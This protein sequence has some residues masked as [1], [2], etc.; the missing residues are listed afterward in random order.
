MAWET[1][2]QDIAKDFI[3]EKVL[4][5]ELVE[6]QWWILSELNSLKENILEP[7]KNFSILWSEITD[8]NNEPQEENNRVFWLDNVMKV[9]FNEKWKQRTKIWYEVNKLVNPTLLM[10]SDEWKKNLDLL[11]ESMDKAEN[12]NELKELLKAELAQLESEVINPWNSNNWWYENLS[13]VENRVEKQVSEQYIYKQAKLYWVTDNRQIAYILAIVKWECGFK[14][15]KEIWWEDKDYWQV[16]PSTWKAYYGRWFLQLTH[17]W[18]YKKYSEIIR[19]S[20]LNFRDNDGNIITWRDVDLEKDPDLVLNSNDLASFILI[21]WMKNWWPYRQE[22]KKLSHYINDNKMDFFN[23]R[24]I[25]NWDKNRLN[26]SGQKIWDMYKWYAEDYLWKLWQWNV[27]VNNI[28]TQLINNR[29]ILAE[30][31]CQL[32]WIGSSIMNW[33]MNDWN[34]VRDPE[35]SF[36][37]MNWINSA[38]TRNVKWF[39]K[40]G[41]ELRYKWK[42][43]GE[44]MELWEY[45]NKHWIRSFMFYFGWNE[46]AISQNAVD[47]AYYDIET[48]A[49][50]LQNK[51]IQPVLCT[52]AYEKIIK[53]SIWHK[54]EKFPLADWPDWKPWFNTKIRNLWNERWWPVIDF[55]KNENNIPISSWDQLH[56]NSDWYLAMRNMIDSGVTKNNA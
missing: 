25:I 5:K 13:S 54:W 38:T 56:P 12:E 40:K 1:R 3:K 4:N 11:F 41:N 37:N 48:W 53:H 24:Y 28:D 39:T 51:W 33:I 19:N 36:I 2:K 55:A 31:R 7:L 21:D 9:L 26:K 49:N 47:T 20:W 8:N 22:T 34:S 46:A 42:D 44:D 32:W 16:D 27:A 15:I 45:C 17:R 29:E 14:N 23:A 35:N 30:K 43:G 50:Y 52:C 6:F 10:I 18:N